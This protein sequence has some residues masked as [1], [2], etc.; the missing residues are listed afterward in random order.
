MTRQE[1]M[2]AI[3]LGTWV[4]LAAGCTSLQGP[5]E[6]VAK[7]AQQRP[8]P[9]PPPVTAASAENT[10][11]ALVPPSPYSPQL[12]P[13]PSLPLPTLAPGS[14]LDQQEPETGFQPTGH[15]PSTDS[16]ETSQRPPIMP[17]PPQ[18]MPSVE[19]QPVK[20]VEKHPLLQALEYLLEKKDSE[21]AVLILKPYDNLTQDLLLHL[22]PFLAMLDQGSVD[23]AKP[24]S[25]VNLLYQIESTETA[26][27]PLVP[28]ILGHM[29]YCKAI[30]GFGVYQALPDDHPFR[31]GD[32]VEVYVE[33]RNF[34][35]KRQ[36][37][38]Y[39]IHLASS[40]AIR[41]SS[42][43]VVWSLNIPDRGPTDKSQSLRHDHFISYHFCIPDRLRSG[44]YTL[45]VRVTDV[46]TKRV[47]EGS[48]ELIVG[49]RPI[50]NP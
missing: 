14:V 39:E 37:P 5:Q 27:R 7:P 41:N 46:E 17:D 21:Q 4:G 28:L 18:Q 32:V 45:E 23:K 11:L 3:G 20:P 16:G 38:Y 25:L 34:F 9:V 22:L 19:A 1:W 47:A 43:Q 35:S 8:L 13:V 6:L 10:S 44:H 30:G 36:P 15:Y 26:L 24:E 48:L 49:T 29:C 31:P 2:R 33:V 50:G 12:V 42:G 40:L